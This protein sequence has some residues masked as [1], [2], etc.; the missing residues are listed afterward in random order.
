MYYSGTIMAN[1]EA[2]IVKY[3]ND[4]IH[5]FDWNGRMMKRVQLDHVFSLFT[6]DFSNDT[7]FALDTESETPYILVYNAFLS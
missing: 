7:L 3:G 4:E 1:E 6:Y 5:V 2:L